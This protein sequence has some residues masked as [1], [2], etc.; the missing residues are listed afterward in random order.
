MDTA[1]AG[2]KAAALGELARAEITV[3]RGYVITVAAFNLVMAAL[4]PSGAI[5]GALGDVPADDRAAIARAAAGLRARITA[6]PLPPEMAAEITVRS[7][8]PAAWGTAVAVRSS[9]TME[10]SPEASFAGLQDSYLAVHGADAVLDRVRSCW[11]SLY[12]DESVSYRRRRGLGE[13]G[14]AMGVVVQRMVRPRAAGVMFTRSPVTGD[15]SVVAIE[16]T[17]GL[18]SALVAGEVTPD[19]FTVSKVTGE[20]TGRRV[21]AKL[22][23]HFFLPNGQGI[24]AQPMPPALRRSPCLTDDEARALALVGRQVEEHYGVPQD[25]EWALLGDGP[26]DPALHADPADRIV[27]LQSRPE[28]VWAVRER[29]PVATPKA[30]ASDHVLARFRTGGGASDGPHGRRRHGH[31]RAARLAAL[32]RAGP[33]DPAVPPYPPPH[34]PRLDPVHP[35]PVRPGPPPPPL[36]PPPPPMETA[37]MEHRGRSSDINAP[38]LPPGADARPASGA[39]SGA[40]EADGDLVAVRAPLPGTF[41]RAPRPGAAPFVEV[42]SQVSADTVIGIVETMKLMNSVHAGVAGTVAEFCVQNAEFAAHGATLL[43]IRADT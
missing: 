29:T 37:A 19:S 34:P 25:I 9:A 35:G 28:T 39:S 6:A 23:A 36:P 27:L 42:G 41:Y 11:A 21:S 24:S 8:L 22:R 18:G 5:R 20:I 1:W 2:G 13:N 31:T 14:L 40:G 26:G 7:C 38:S 16:G 43:R 17:W 15:R 3:P 30:R 33:G 12:N 10:D 32:R 4:D